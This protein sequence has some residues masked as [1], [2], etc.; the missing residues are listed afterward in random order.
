[1]HWAGLVVDP[2]LL[3]AGLAVLVVT[4]GAAVLAVIGRSR[5]NALPAWGLGAL[6]AVAATLVALVVT[7]LPARLLWP[8]NW[9][10]LATNVD[11]GFAGIADQ[12]DPYPY[13]GE[14]AWSRLAILLGAPL[15]L[16]LAA[17]ASFWPRRPWRPQTLLGVKRSAP[18]PRQALGILGLAVLVLLYAVPATEIPSSAPLLGGLALFLLVAGWLWLPGLRHREARMAAALVAVAGAFALPL[19]TQLEDAEGW[20]DYRN[21]AW[22]SAGGGVTFDWEHSYGPIDWPRDDRT[23]LRVE[24]EDALYWKLATLGRFDGRRWLRSTGP[25]E[26][27]ELPGEVERALQFPLL[28][29]PPAEWIRNARFEVGELRSDLVVGAGVIRT[30]QGLGKNAPS[31]ANGGTWELARPL[32]EGD[33]YELEVYAP[34]PGANRMRS[35]E[36]RYPRVLEQATEIGLLGAPASASSPACQSPGGCVAL[37]SD[38]DGAGPGELRVVDEVVVPLRGRNASPRRVARAEERLL[39]SPYAQ[40]FD[41]AEELTADEPTSYDAAKAVETHLR[42]NYA[43]SELPPDHTFP[44]SDFLFEDRVGYCQQFSGAMALMLRMVGIPSR[45]VTGFAPGRRNLEN[46]TFTVRNLDAHSWVEVF[47]NEIGWV[48]FDPTP[49]AAPAE[50]QLSETTA[51]RGGP[52]GQASGGFGD[53]GSGDE[54]GGGQGATA[55]D[56][57]GE[58]RSPLVLLPVAVLV[59]ALAGLGLIGARA[60][61]SRRLAPSA[62]AAAQLRELESALP[63]LGWTLAPGAT[64]LGLERAMRQ[65]VG[66]SGVRY[67]AKLRA[68]RYAVGAPAPPSR[69]ERRALRRGLGSKRGMRARLVAYLALPPWGPRP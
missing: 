8:G 31:K 69:E 5:L 41:L 42:E 60:I 47:F 43:Y 46:E 18:P 52:G 33:A 57:A 54:N 3:R 39:A 62:V 44:L 19:A 66:A 59:L 50:S 34:D 36:G 24:S 4:A 40:M 67:I 20:I 65:A 11:I 25:E 53:P 23:V 26:P 1:M 22:N 14:N 51:G 68:R 61:G 58:G 21:W 48:T 30:I 15:L 7:G 35:A 38:V 10:E 32:E 37:P 45:V 49:A 13:A 9:V 28:D 16:G 2:P 56:A 29:P 6:T 12:V 17:A 27:L 63:R 64:L 55:A